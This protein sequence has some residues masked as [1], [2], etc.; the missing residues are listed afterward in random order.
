MSNR[1]FS[2]NGLQALIQ[3]EGGICKSQYLDS[4]GYPTIGVGHLLTQPERRSGCITIGDMSCSYIIGLTSQQCTQLLAQDCHIVVAALADKLGDAADRLTQHQFDAL[5][6]WTFNV[7]IS[8]MR[9]SSLVRQILMGKL[10]DVPDELR[11]WNKA[12]GV[13]VRGL[14]NR[15]EAEVRYWLGL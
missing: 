8:A 10:E 15:R 6:M 1:I 9:T 3:L 7:G 4:A 13:V 14:V 11:R 2:T 5:V 12:G